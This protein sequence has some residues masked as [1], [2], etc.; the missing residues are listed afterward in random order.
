MEEIDRLKEAADFIKKRIK[1][2]PEIGLILG[3]GL[4][5]LADEI[6]DSV[7]IDYKSIPHFPVST[8]EGHAGRMV[9]G[10]LNERAVLAFQGR[11]HYYEGYNM[12][13]VVFPVRVM[14][15]LGIN[16]LLVTNASG[17]VNKRFKPGDLMII[18]DHILFYTENPL[19]GSNLDELGPRFNDMSDAYNRNLR[20][21]AKDAAEKA[22]VEVQEGVYVFM[23]GPSYETPAEIRAVRVLGGDAVGM[24]TVPEVIAA[25]HAGMRVIGISCITNMAAGILDQPL[26]HE[27]VME[28]ADKVKSKFLK[29]V[30]A[31]VAEWNN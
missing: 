16:N 18:K 31:I 28:T 24:S 15:L 2:S 1:D 14:K 29:L 9:I 26:K 25:S 6:E 12:D 7:F 19:R 20:T 22:R 13:K 5:V 4:G 27:E 30:K 17:G 8:V 10:K 11:F 21:L 23:G 3:S